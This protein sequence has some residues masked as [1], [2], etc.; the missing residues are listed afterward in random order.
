LARIAGREHDVLAEPVACVRGERSDHDGRRQEHDEHDAGLA[1]PAT[2][3]GEHGDCQPGG[4]LADG[5]Q[6]ERRQQPAHGRV[7]HDPHQLTPPT[8]QRA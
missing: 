6:P 4:V 5:E 1:H 3:V 7:A 8:V 2:P